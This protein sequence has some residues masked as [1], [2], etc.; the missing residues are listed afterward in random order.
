MPEE[1][2]QEIEELSE[3]SW[4]QFETGDLWRDRVQQLVFETDEPVQI[5]QENEVPEEWKLGKGIRTFTGITEFG[6]RVMVVMNVLDGAMTEAKA[7]SAMK[8]GL[9]IRKRYVQQGLTYRYW[10]V[11]VTET[12]EDAARMIAYAIS[13]GDN[14]LPSEEV[15]R[16]DFCTVTG[17]GDLF[18]VAYKHWMYLPMRLIYLDIIHPRCYIRF[19]LEVN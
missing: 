9:E 17:R 16:C 10:L 15:M 5:L 14:L 13:A 18:C 6:P 3:P 8:D 2:I 12:E 19:T 7:R 1:V 11:E 4:Q